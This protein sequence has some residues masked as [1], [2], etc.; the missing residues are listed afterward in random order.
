VTNEQL[1]ASIERSLYRAFVSP[2][3]PDRNL[4]PACVVDGLF[5]IARAVAKLARAV[6]DLSPNMEARPSVES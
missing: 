1:S 6:E 4:E 2:N 3:E 5:A